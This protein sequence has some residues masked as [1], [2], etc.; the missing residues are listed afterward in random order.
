[1]YGDNEDLLAKWYAYLRRESPPR[2][3][4]MSTAW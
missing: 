3:Q 2:L 4:S 1:M